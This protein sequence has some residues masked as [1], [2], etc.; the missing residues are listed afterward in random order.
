MAERDI[1]GSYPRELRDWYGLYSRH[2]R[3]KLGHDA[4]LYLAE[5]ALRAMTSVMLSIYSEDNRG[6][7]TPFTPYLKHRSS[8]GQQFELFRKC[9]DYVEFLDLALA[10]KSLR[11]CCRL[12]SAV[13]A[14]SDLGNHAKAVEIAINRKSSVQ[15]T[16]LSA[17]SLLVQY[18]NRTLGHPDPSVIGSL[19]FYSTLTPVLAGAVAELLWQPPV[20]EAME[21]WRFATLRIIQPPLSYEI[22]YHGSAGYERVATLEGDDVQ[23]MKLEDKLLIEFREGAHEP[24]FRAHCFDLQ[25]WLQREDAPEPMA[26]K[27][28]ELRHGLVAVE[29]GTAV[30][31]RQ[32]EAPT[33]ITVDRAFAIGCYPVTQQLYRDVVGEDLSISTGDSLPVVRVSW[34]DCIRFCNALS[35]M[36]GFTPAYEV[37]EAGS[38]E[39]VD[40]KCDGYR[41]PT[42]HEWVF[43]CLGGVTG[44][45]YPELNDAA[46]FK[47]NSGK[48]THPVGQK[49]PNGL[50]IFDMLGNVAE[51]CQD[52]W[53]RDFPSGWSDGPE[54]GSHRTCR[55]GSCI[56]QA[57]Q[58]TPHSRLKIF[59]DSR[60]DYIG[61]R[62][63]RT[64][65]SQFDSSQ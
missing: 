62:V 53:Q 13:K 51:W 45:G 38:V 64:L 40:L 32:G 25:Q 50:G 2:P 21:R 10:Q 58:V 39:Q 16:Y 30:L 20:N 7:M 33:P 46:W 34:R 56:D 26:V 12:N 63:A 52:R 18:R 54:K 22:S 3:E 9:L 17:W 14:L 41:L 5:D 42:E 23:G 36:E 4:L 48:H 57:P 8:F 29:P 55:G 11:S 60:R 43:A 24:V 61:F 27:E 1:P 28:V 47:T 6:Q 49:D 44:K 35:E 37:S 65:R 15:L 19:G 59:P 31:V